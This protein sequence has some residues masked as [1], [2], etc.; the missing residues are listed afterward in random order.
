MPGEPSTPALWTV[1][2]GEAR[3]HLFGGR[4]PLPM[5]WSAPDVEAALAAAEEFWNE[6]PRVAPEQQSLALELGI[7]PEAPLRA[8]L[9]EEELSRVE[10]AASE[11]GVAREVLAPFRPWLAGQVLRMAAES[12]C[13]IDPESRPESILRARAEQAG[14][15]IRHE[16]SSLREAAELFSELPRRA[17][18]ELLLFNLDEVQADP[19]D[20]EQRAKAW[21]RGDL[22]IEEA[23]STR[24]RDEYPVFFRHLVVARNQ[25]WVP[26][27]AEMLERR[28]RALIVVGIGHLVGPDNVRDLLANAGFDVER[29]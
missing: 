24:N 8:W 22:T 28:T 2:R 16:L 10:H 4:P 17:E 3:I 15:R 19:A 25:A 7:D 26:R 9:T 20:D 1:R 6:T 12:R 27:I 23:E 5:P 14:L 18:V 21:L 13:G 29:V 11:L